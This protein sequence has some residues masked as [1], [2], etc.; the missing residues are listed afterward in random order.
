[1]TYYRM[2]LQ[3]QQTT[4]WF[5]KTS[6]LTSLQAVFQLLRSLSALPQNHIR[7]FTASSKEDLN[8][9]LRCENANV[10]SGSATMAQFLQERKLQVPGRVQSAPGQRVAEQV[11][12]QATTVAITSPLHE[13][14]TT[15]G[16]SGSSDMSS[17]EKKRLEIECGPGSDHDTPYRFTLPTCTPQLLAWIRLQSQVQAGELQS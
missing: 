15:I 2:A 7:V 4:A 13:H 16:F 1:M 9:M 6:A 14:R 10:A 17:L 5:W 12:R 3:N 11:V 8:E